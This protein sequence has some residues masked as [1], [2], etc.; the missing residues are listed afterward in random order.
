MS[1]FTLALEEL[2]KVQSHETSFF[3]QARVDNPLLIST[4]EE[5][6]LAPTAWSWMDAAIQP[7]N[8]QV[9]KELWDQ[10]LTWEMG[11]SLPYVEQALRA[12]SNYP[13]WTPILSTTLVELMEANQP[14]DWTALL[15]PEEMQSNRFGYHLMHALCLNPK[16]FPEVSF[17]TVFHL[18]MESQSIR[19][20]QK[21]LLCVH[22]L[23]MDDASWNRMFSQANGDNSLLV[24]AEWWGA[25]Q[26]KFP[27]RHSWFA[28]WEMLQ[29]SMD[30]QG[31]QRTQ[32]GLQ[33]GILINKDGWRKQAKSYTLQDF[34]DS[35]SD[36]L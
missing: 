2:E 33:W 11:L 16:H 24:P 6:A 7:V 4:W 26:G 5:L 14:R 25:I 20:P 15:V 13:V 23:N 18:L 28:E 9:W 34:S 36:L 19:P 17:N 22:L 27:W 31:V 32:L 35:P 21:E 12:W 8:S 30:I 29:E 1:I 3:W 10:A